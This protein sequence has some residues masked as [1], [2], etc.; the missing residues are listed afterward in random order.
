M[1]L[2]MN[3]MQIIENWWIDSHLIIIISLW[4]LDHWTKLHESSRLE[5]HIDYRIWMRMIVW[6]ELIS[7]I[8]LAWSSISKLGPEGVIQIWLCNFWVY[9][10]LDWMTH[11]HF[12]FCWKLTRFNTNLD[13]KL[14]SKPFYII[15]SP[16]LIKIGRPSL[17]HIM[18]SID[19]SQNKHGHE[20]I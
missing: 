1:S 8:E 12:G 15:S 20:K 13:L 19:Y 16:P 11:N 9:H 5:L 3:Q 14:C 6:L 4:S 18:L 2:L 10:R 17:F 7:H